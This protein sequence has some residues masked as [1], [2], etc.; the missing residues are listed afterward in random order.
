MPGSAAM[1]SLCRAHRGAGG[2]L[3]KVPQV[4][5]QATPT[6]TQSP[7]SLPDLTGVNVTLRRELLECSLGILTL[8]ENV[9]TEECDI[10]GGKLATPG[11]AFKMVLP[12]GISFK[13]F[14][15]REEL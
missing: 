12:S 7:A 8:L 6:R 1:R 13:E 14:I 15:L 2:S 4:L 5:T 9:H 3:R 11:K 10:S